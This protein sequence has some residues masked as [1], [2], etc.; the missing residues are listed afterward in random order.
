MIY[1]RLEFVLSVANS[2]WHPSRPRSPVGMP[3]GGIYHTPVTASYG[4]SQTIEVLARKKYRPKLFYQ[5]NSG[6]WIRARFKQRFGRFYND[7]PGLFYTRY[8]AEIQGQQEG[9]TVTYI[10]KSRRNRLGPYQYRVPNASGHPILV[11]AAED[12]TGEFPTYADPSGPNYLQFYTE[13]LNAAGYAYDVWDVDRQGIPSHIEVLSHY[14]AAI[15]YTGDDFTPTVPI[16][17]ATHTEETLAF[18]DYLNYS[19]GKLFVTGQDLAWISAVYLQYDDIP[20][21]FFQYYLGAFM[22]I[23]TGGMDPDSGLPFAVRGEAGDPVFDGLNFEIQ[24]SEGAD[25]QCCSSTFLATSYFLPHFEDNIAARY[26]RPGGPFDPHSGQYYVYSQM[27]DQAF[28]RIGRTVTLPADSPEL[29]FWI[30]Y[31]IEPDWD[32]AFVEIREAGS[33]IWTTLPDINGQTT[34]STGESCTEGWVTRIHPFL[35]HY[36]DE[37]CNPQG[38][39]G[40]WHAFTGNSS[41]WQLVAMDL[42]DYAGKTVEINISYAT[43]WTTQNLGVFVDDI[44]ISGQIMEDFEFGLGDWTVSVAPGSEALNNWI[45]MTGAGFPEG[46][47]MRTADS[48]YLGFGFE[49]IDTLHNRTAVMDR[50]M[51]Y[52]LSN[53]D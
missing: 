42:S 20:D 37:S 36:M 19:N 32:Y 9:D 31:D 51:Q 3:A 7:A 1:T 47:A 52:L 23:D 14:D 53:P 30:S 35:A 24:G 25:N 18:R 15:W 45:R 10:L 41:G 21:D 6:G 13:A 43:E 49:A 8:V 38:S 34:Q 2:A 28:K 4:T 12:Y 39:T 17:L 11:V 16:G 46:P 29:K 50:V 33:D 44:E 22:D 26:D 40:D 5:I 48:V 27:A